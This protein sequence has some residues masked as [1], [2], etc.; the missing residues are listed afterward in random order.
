MTFAGVVL[1]ASLLGSVH[2]A[3][4][5]GA[6]TCLYATPG[7]GAA[8]L[9]RDLPAHLAY[10][11]GRLVAYLTLGAAAGALGAGID[12]AGALAGVVRLAPLLA[13]TMMIA[14]GLHALLLATG[15]RLPVLGVPAG[16]RSLLT[17]GVGRLADRPPV[18]RAA[19]VGLASGLLPCGWLHAFLLTAAGSGTPL[20]GATLMAIF[21]L[22][23]VPMMLAVGLGLQRLFGPAR[24]RLPAIAATMVLLLG[25][26][27]LAGHF[28]VLPGAAWLHRL[29][30]DVPVVGTMPTA[31]DG[32]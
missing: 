15:V 14:W 19:S 28:R 1:L 6:F 2:C 11:L 9:T 30:P 23:T 4:M 3:A 27:S 31:D 13:A 7:R 5:C 32:H 26:L 24:R 17:R 10:N 29:T 22:G 8:P 12:R 21:W 25:A 20:R 18:V 16:W